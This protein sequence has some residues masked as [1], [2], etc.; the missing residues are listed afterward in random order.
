MR[1]D[2]GGTAEVI[3]GYTRSLGYSLSAV[4]EEQ[5]RLRTLPAWLGPYGGIG[6]QVVEVFH[7]QET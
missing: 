3:K 2:I 6:L 1:D 4:F 7:P 5:V